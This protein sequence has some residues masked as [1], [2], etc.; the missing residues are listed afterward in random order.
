MFVEIKENVY[1]K[2]HVS[3]Q[4]LI[5]YSSNLVIKFRILHTYTISCTIYIIIFLLNYHTKVITPGVC[6]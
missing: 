2:N 3:V 4:I 6:Q 5:Y 1:L